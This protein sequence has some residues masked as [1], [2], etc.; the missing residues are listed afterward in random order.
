M[1]TNP[2]TWIY[3]LIDAVPG[4]L[5]SPARWIADRVFGVFDD[6]VEFAKWIKS[7]VEHLRDKGIAFSDSIWLFA[8]ETYTTLRWLAETRIPALISSASITIR[9]W[10]TNAINAAV[11]AVKSSL[12][13]LD[14]WARSAVAALA[15]ALTSV[16][17]W[18][19]AKINAV[20]D[21]L[22]RT[23]D[24]WYERLT[25]PKKFASWV[26]GAVIL[27]LLNYAYAHRDEIARWL[28]RSSPAFTQW[29]AR[30]LETVLRKIL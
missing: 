13:A 1:A 17:D 26:I 11:N 10:A 21:R 16:R 24:V 14:R 19:S 6:G 7:G 15:D 27:A 29:L 30:E 20:T 22:R 23:V 2:R 3:A 12:S 18:L 28:L 4:F 5:S 8:S 25:D 9:T